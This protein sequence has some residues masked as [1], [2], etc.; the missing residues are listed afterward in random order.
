MLIDA[1]A[2]LRR[3]LA[4]PFVYVAPDGGNIRCGWRVT[5]GKLEKFWERIPSER[6]EDS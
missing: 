6:S 4:E 3:I 2:E 1:E 5:N